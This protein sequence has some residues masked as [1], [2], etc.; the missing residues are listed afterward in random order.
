MQR[1]YPCIFDKS[2]EAFFKVLKRLLMSQEMIINIP[3]LISNRPALLAYAWR[4]PFARVRFQ[5]YD[6]TPRDRSW[7][8]NMTQEQGLVDNRDEISTCWILAN[9]LKPNSN[10]SMG[11]P[12]YTSRQAA[13]GW[14][15]AVLVHSISDIDCNVADCIKIIKTSCWE[16]G[17]N[18][19][20]AQFG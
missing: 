9:S 3:W 11:S 15:I 17:L 8:K 18:D 19:I 5:R 12:F 10:M 16:A 13:D 2:H 14:D 7:P 1:P 4:L 6:R 20:D